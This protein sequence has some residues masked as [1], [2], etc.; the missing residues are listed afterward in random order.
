MMRKFYRI[1]KGKIAF[2][3]CNGLGQYFN[4]D[5]VLIRLAFVVLTLAS[6][7]SAIIF[8]LIASLVT[9]VMES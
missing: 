8:Y 5:P 2:G 1:K 4:I 3:L 9:P 6:I 7:G